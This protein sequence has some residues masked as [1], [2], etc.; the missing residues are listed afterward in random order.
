MSV[1]IHNSEGYVDPTA[2][3]AISGI[4]RE[5][6]SAQ[7]IQANRL[8]LLSLCRRYRDE[9]GRCTQILVFA[10]EK[11]CIPIAPH[12]LFPQFLNDGDPAERELGLFFGNAIMT[13]AR[14]SGIR[15]THL[16][17][18]GGRNQTRTLEELPPALFHRRIGGE[19]DV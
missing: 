6:R 5:E 11:G 2:F 9:R 12:L 8:Y 7:G 16:K 15:R 13:S 3:E 1:D 19:N 14:K 4:E 18:H 10:V 17:R